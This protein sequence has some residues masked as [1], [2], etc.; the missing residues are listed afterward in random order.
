MERANR[1]LKY[2][3][4]LQTYKWRRRRSHFDVF[5]PMIFFVI[6]RGGCAW[7]ARLCSRSFWR[8][9]FH[10]FVS[11]SSKKW[12]NVTKLWI[13]ELPPLVFA[14][15][16]LLWWTRA[17]TTISWLTNGNIRLVKSNRVSPMCSFVFHIFF[18]AVGT[19]CLAVTKFSR[20]SAKSFF[21]IALHLESPSDQ[22]MSVVASY[23]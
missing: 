12:E 5:I 23:T 21:L 22:E 8:I 20:I 7:N 10:F 9:F 6:M 19:K 2:K 18:F 16:K 11:H 14:P 17:F 4:S 1:K 15:R 3:V 13:E